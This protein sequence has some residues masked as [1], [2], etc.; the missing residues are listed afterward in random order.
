MDLTQAFASFQ[1]AV[2]AD[3]DQV[4][5]ARERRGVFKKAIKAEPGVLDV[6]GSGSLAR[7]T[8]L[9]PVHDVDL[10]AVFDGDAYPEWGQPGDSSADAL[11][12]VREMVKRL[13]GDPDGTVDE[14]VRL[15][16]PRDRAVKCFI[17]PPEQD[18]AFTVDVMP[19]L[20]QTD[21]TLLVPSKR[22]QYWS[23]ANPEYLIAQVEERQGKWS[24]FRPMV[25]VLK[26]W[27]H[28]VPTKVKSLVME[29]LALK[30]LP[31]EGSR[32]EALKTFFTAAAVEVNYGVEDPAK[33]CGPIQP[34]LDIEVLRAALESARDTAEEACAAAA[35]GDTDGA[36]VL[37]RELLGEDFP[38][39]EEKASTGAAAAGAFLYVP[40]PV[41]DA[42]QG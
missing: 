15:A 40:R 4:R 23:T 31:T 21:G 13:L 10:I 32:P 1:D 7:S 18:D 14:L 29:V 22:K 5:L 30:C 36:A 17:D 19:A 38:A 26:Q 41:V 25:R 28:G 9:K 27:R 42:P 11:E 16:K 20:R 37:W 12:V 8:Q 34:D 33:H 24:S 6:F 35:E 3:I 39:P 2:D